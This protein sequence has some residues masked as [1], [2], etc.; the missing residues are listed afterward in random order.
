M[1]THLRLVAPV[2]EWQRWPRNYE[3]TNEQL[4]AMTEEEYDAWARYEYGP[5]QRSK[6]HPVFGERGR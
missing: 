4:E 3:P 6:N 2:A 5:P 1:N